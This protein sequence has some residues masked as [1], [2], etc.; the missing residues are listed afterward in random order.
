[1]S[2]SCCSFLS[3]HSYEALPHME[4]DTIAQELAELSLKMFNVNSGINMIL[5]VFVES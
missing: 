2:I 3:G 5:P 1:M 4:S